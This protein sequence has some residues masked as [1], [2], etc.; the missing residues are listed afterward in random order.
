M[1][2]M[3]KEDYNLADKLAIPPSIFDRLSK[4]DLFIL[5]KNAPDQI[6]K[7]WDLE[8]FPKYIINKVYIQ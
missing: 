5:E 4:K 2:I 1:G 3:S 7:Y 8:T 6:E